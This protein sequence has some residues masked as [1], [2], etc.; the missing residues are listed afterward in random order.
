MP[1]LYKVVAYRVLRPL[2]AALLLTSLLTATGQ[3]SAK[4]AHRDYVPDE[5]TAVRVAEA[6]LI[7]QFG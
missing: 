3:T 5:K 2:A 4:H 1:M 6:I 7:A